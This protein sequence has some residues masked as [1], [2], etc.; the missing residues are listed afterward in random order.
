MTLDEL[1]EQ[2]DYAKLPRHIAIIMD[3]NGRWAKRRFLPRVIGHRAGVRVVDKIV[4]QCCKL[5]VKALT[6]FSFS[7]ENWNRPKKEINFLMSLLSEYLQKELRRMVKENIR[8]NTIGHIDELPLSVQEI[9]EN[10]KE[11]TRDKTGMVLTLAL[12]YGSRREIIETVRKIA[13]KVKKGVL[14][15]DSINTDLFSQELYTFDLP[16]PDLLIRT[17][18]EMRISNYLLYQIAYT[19]LYFTDVL[20]PDFNETQLLEAIVEFQNRLRRYGL[21]SEQVIKTKGK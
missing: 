10:A 9:I 21:T 3:G 7:D 1:K 4:T 6:L 5:G 16:E 14:D 12:S 18:G 19:E 20:W 8:F 17:S 11:Q 13:E 2:V 15:L